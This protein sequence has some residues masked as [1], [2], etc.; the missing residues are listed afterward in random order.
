MNKTGVLQNK[1]FHEDVAV[2]LIATL[3]D[4]LSVKSPLMPL[5]REGIKICEPKSINDFEILAKLS[6]LNSFLIFLF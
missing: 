6:W 5:I 2:N 3:Y 4:S 1:V